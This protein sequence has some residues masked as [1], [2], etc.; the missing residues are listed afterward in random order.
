MQ[1]FRVSLK[2]LKKNIPTLLIYIVIFLIISL[3]FASFARG[4]ESEYSEFVP[5][6]TSVAFFAEE[7]TP[8][9]EGFKNELS[10]TAV[11]VDIEDDYDKIMDAL[12]FRNVFYVLRIPEGFTEKI[13][14]GEEVQLE[15]RTVP[16]SISNIYTDLAINTYFNTA[17]LYVSQEPLLS[18]EDLVKKV[19]LSLAS[20]TDISIET[21]GESTGTNGYG[22]YYFN[23]LAYSLVSILIMGTS[24]VMLVWKDIN[25]YRRTEISPLERG[26]INMGKFLALAVFTLITWFVLIISYFFLSGS[27]AT[28]VKSLLYL[29]NSLTF[30]FTALGLSFLI[31]TLLK[32]RN[33]INAVSNV[34]SLG[35]SFISGVFVP[36]EL[37]G[38][39]VL[40]LARVT[41]TFWYVTANI[42]ID[43]LQGL[44]NEILGQILFNT[45]IVFAFG[46]GFFVLA[47]FLGKRRRFA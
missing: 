9:V 7:S 10:K 26:K 42:K 31:G 4:Q 8:L 14:N 47:Y 1:V 28:D 37:L 20:T 36:Q 18:Q 30:A 2:I 41:P 38:E 44:T 3:L 39:N 17:R 33:A 24:I 11:F 45:A 6:K 22:K 46:I 32:N 21:G 12:Y 19:T 27:L 34:L 23:Y 5:V 35:P 13:M 15:K 40:A 25:L 43:A 16:N 29:F